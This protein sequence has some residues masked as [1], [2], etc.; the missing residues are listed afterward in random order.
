MEAACPRTTFIIRAALVY[1]RTDRTTRISGKENRVR[2][3]L[4]EQVNARKLR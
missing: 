2:T 1:N 4:N 3:P